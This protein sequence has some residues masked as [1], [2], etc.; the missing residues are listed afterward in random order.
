M[1]TKGL[2]VFLFL[3]GLV[4]AH[5]SDIQPVSSTQLMA[6]LTSGVPGNRLVRIVQERGFAGVLSKDQIRQLE[7]AGADA[8]LI[9]SL[10]GTK[11]APDSA[12]AE[13]SAPLLKAATD[14]HAQRYH[15]AELALRQALTTDPQNA[16]LHFALGTM[17]RQ[18]NDAPPPAFSTAG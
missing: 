16:A 11:P 7:A 15:E 13:I 10:T 2:S 8:N 5:S 18:H 4:L 1:K 6:W 3:A 17:L 9:R 12:A 14:A